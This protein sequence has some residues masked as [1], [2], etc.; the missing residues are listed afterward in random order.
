[1]ADHQVIIS[2]QIIKLIP[3]GF[4]ACGCGGKTTVAKYNCKRYRWIKGIPKK[5]IST[6]NNKNKNGCHN[7]NWR[8]G[9]V[10]HEGYK[11]NYQPNHPR[12]DKKGYVP[13]QVLVC[14]KALG[15]Y[16]PNKAIPHHVNGK[17]DDNLPSNLVVCQ[18]VVYHNLLHQR[19]RAFESCGHASWRKCVFCKKYDDPVNLSGNNRRSYHK[20]CAKLYMLNR[21]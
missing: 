1:M 15:K 13:E 19:Q 11:D 12:A 6:H 18:D 8:G 3:L 7:L 9:T 20:K 10:N 17:R 16:L 4:C 5:F 2:G 21:K 14:E